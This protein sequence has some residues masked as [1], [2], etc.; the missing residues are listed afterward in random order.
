MSKQSLDFS[1]RKDLPISCGTM[2]INGAGDILLC[3]VTGHDL[4]DLPKGMQE[5]GEPAVHTARRELHEETSLEFAEEAF[6]E[7]GCF[8]FRPDKRLHLF[9]VDAAQCVE[10]IA[11]LRCISHFVHPVTGEPTPEMDG[12]RWATREDVKSLCGPNMQR[13]LLGIDW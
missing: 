3:H 6:V 1:T 5:P 9:R 12:F 2:V 8:D 13:V 11:G 7:I 4:W 10:S